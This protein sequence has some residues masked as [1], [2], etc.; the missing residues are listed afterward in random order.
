MVELSRGVSEVSYTEVDSHSVAAT[1]PDIHQS[2]RLVELNKHWSG[3][4]EGRYG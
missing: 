1:H 2:P 3:A 4:G